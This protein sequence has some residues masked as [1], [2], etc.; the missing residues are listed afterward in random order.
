[1]SILRV[2]IR[3]FLLVLLLPVLSRADGVDPAKAPGDRMSI[4]V[5]PCESSPAVADL[6]QVADDLLVKAILEKKRFRVVEKEKLQ[7]VVQ[8]QLL[9]QK[10]LTDPEH[11]VR[12]GRIASA[13]A[14]LATR[15][16]EEGKSLRLTA[17][18]ILTETGVSLELISLKTEHSLSGAREMGAKLAA[19]L[20]QLLPLVEGEV[21]RMDGE[22][23]VVRL[24]GAGTVSRGMKLIIYR[25]GKEIRHPVTGRSL[26]FDVALLGE[27]TAVESAQ[28]SVWIRLSDRLRAKDVRPGD[29]AVTK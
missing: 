10:K 20:T 26:G 29:R 14:L 12:L 11:S 3:S 19:A 17:R 27:A 24:F 6:A 5:F 22:K 25:R 2:C 13:E 9:S 15:L 21:T 1:M 23:A 4:L 8:E 18:V 7:Q 28:G 16:L